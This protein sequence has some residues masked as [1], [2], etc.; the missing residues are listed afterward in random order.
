[1]LTPLSWHFYRLCYS[2]LGV[3]VEFEYVLDM[4]VFEFFEV[5][6]VLRGSYSYNRT[7]ICV[8]D[9]R[10]NETKRVGVV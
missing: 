5:F 2:D 8:I 7:W 3:D 10:L 1:M 9:E 6:H 4:S